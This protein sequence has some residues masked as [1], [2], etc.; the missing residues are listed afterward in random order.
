MNNK[1][2]RVYPIRKTRK[3]WDIRLFRIHKCNEKC[4][5]DISIENNIINIKDNLVYKEGKCDKNNTIEKTI[6]N[7]SNFNI[8]TAE[9]DGNGILYKSE[10]KVIPDNSFSL[11]INFPLSYNFELIIRNDI[12]KGFTLKE[13]IK[14]IKKLYKFIYEEEERTATPQTIEIKKYCITCENKDF[15]KYIKTISTD[16]INEECSICYNELN[17]ASHIANLSC[18]HLFHFDCVKTWF[19]NNGKC[20][21]CRSNVFNCNNCDGSGIIYYNFVGI[22]VPIEER[23]LNLQRNRTNGIFGIYDYDYEDL[24]IQKLSYDRIKKKLCIKLTY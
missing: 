8:E 24:Y 9:L 22:V 5:Y 15:N 2:L 16:N 11:S 19:I 18:N 10:L 1:I 23:G 6:I 13:L 14:Y 17:T 3:R 21:I 12:K 7:I 20:P 4:K